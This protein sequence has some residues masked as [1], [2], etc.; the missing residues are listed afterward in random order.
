MRIL[1]VGDIAG[2]V[3]RGVLA[4]HLPDLLEQEGV[5]FC[6]VNAENT[7]GGIGL[8]Q[9]TMAELMTLDI[10]VLTMGNH[11]WDKREIYGFIDRSPRLL[12]PLN[13]PPGTPG[14][15]FG[16][17]ESKS[18][19]SVAVF[20]AM[21]RVF[22]G[23]ALDC[24]FRGLDQALA[25]IPSEVRVRLLDF[26]AE[27]TSE[28]VAMGWYLDGRLSAVVGTHTHIQTAD[29][30]VLPKGTAYITDLGMTGPVDSVLGMNKEQVLEKF[31][32]QR[33]VRFEAA[34][35]RGELR[36]VLIDVDADTGRA[37]EITR[38]VRRGSG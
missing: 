35:G 10:D 26:H 18:G 32:M 1:M 19:T 33:P 28:K 20:N 29:E 5:D 17:Y 37:R 38:V 24:P 30:R 23:V 3:G 27:A 34:G 16:V 36:G 15:G 14:R 6:V 9:E 25:A 22:S 8:T 4:E 21:G 2:R 7:A 31:L 11:T 12:R 13:Y